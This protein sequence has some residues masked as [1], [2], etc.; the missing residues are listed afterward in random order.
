MYLCRA[1]GQC[2][3]GFGAAL[4]LEPAAVWRLCGRESGRKTTWQGGTWQ[5]RRRRRKR[6]GAESCVHA[7][8]I[9]RGG[10][11]KISRGGWERRGIVV[12]QR[13][14]Q[15]GVG[16][17][18]PCRRQRAHEGPA[19]QAAQVGSAGGKGQNEPPPV[20]GAARG[21]RNGS[22]RGGPAGRDFDGRGRAHRPRSTHVS[23][24][25]VCARL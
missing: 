12:C 19:G 8:I 5:G 14:W 1:S 17:P 11:I 24:T 22:S 2:G 23:L 13:G 20:W 25:L 15:R 9:F 21:E 18:L 7:R 10:P 6:T 16:K 3:T 4:K